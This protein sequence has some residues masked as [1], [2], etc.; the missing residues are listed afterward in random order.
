M[1]K[2]CQRWHTRELVNVDRGNN[3]VTEGGT[4]DTPVSFHMTPV[5]RER[6][7]R[8]PLQSAVSHGQRTLNAIVDANPCSIESW[9]GT[10][11]GGKVNYGVRSLNEDKVLVDQRHAKYDKFR[12]HTA[13]HCRR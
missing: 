4:R 11:F 10:D 8:W 1:R 9:T 6:E 7:L 5:T 12:P 3:R 2:H 13:L